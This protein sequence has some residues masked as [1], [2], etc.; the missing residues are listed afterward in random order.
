MTLTEADAA[1][2][3]AAGQRDFFF[4]NDDCDLQLLNVD[5]HC[6]FLVNGLC[7]VHDDRPE[8]CRL[9]PLILDLSVDRVVLDSFCP[10][11]TDFEFNRDDTVELRRSVTDEE[12]EAR[13]RAARKR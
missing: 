9:Y 11:A 6:I 12:R 8:G 5:G 10:W 7:S 1:R 3:D 4:V 13:L 2:L